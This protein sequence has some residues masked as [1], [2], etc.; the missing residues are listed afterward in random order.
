MFTGIIRAVSPILSLSMKN[1]NRV[2]RISTPEKWKLEL[3]QS[4][5]IDGVCSTVTKL[6]D[7]SFEVYWMPETLLKTTTGSLVEGQ[8][9]NLERSLTLQDFVDG[10]LVQGHVDT[11][12]TVSDISKTTD[13]G[14]R[15]TVEVPPTLKKFIAEKGSISVNGVSLTV[16]AESKN[17]FTVALI[18]YTLEHT[19]LGI[20]KNGSPVNIEVDMMARYAAAHVKNQ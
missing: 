16:A 6:D 5:A 14:T 18:P 11:R 8:S 20:L 13:G 2:A 7:T 3:G 9:V 19:T 15:I 4:I 17:T 1:E 10:H 12:G